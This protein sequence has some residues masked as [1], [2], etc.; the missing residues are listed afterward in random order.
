MVSATSVPGSA[1]QEAPEAEQQ[2]PGIWL[3]KSSPVSSGTIS[4]A[5][6]HLGEPGLRVDVVA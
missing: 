4:Y 1:R 3:A 2:D 6:E 5:G